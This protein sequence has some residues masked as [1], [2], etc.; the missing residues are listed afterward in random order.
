M[1]SEHQRVESLSDWYLKEQLDFDKRLIRFRY[2]ALKPHLKGPRGL[3]LGPAEGEMTQFLIND[4]ESLT[5]VDGAAELLTHIPDRENLVKVHSLFEEFEPDACFDSIIMEHIL[6][7]VDE[8]VALLGSIKHWLVPGG[9]LFLGVPNGNSIHRLVAVKMG[10]LKH[11]CQLNPRD[12]ALGHRRVYTPGT[13][14]K[15]I[16]EAGISVETIGGIFFKPLSNAQIQENWTEEM[17]Q[18]F[19]ELGNDFP[20]L[21]AEIYAVC[22]LP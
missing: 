21:A 15:D 16:E 19:S 13:F 18:G 2:E 6:E 1:N 22:T 5:V 10:L 3:E 14:R 20:E 7:H 4:F 9:K 17:I 8:P 12:H 11:P